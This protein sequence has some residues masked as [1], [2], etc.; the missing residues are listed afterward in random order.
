MAHFFLV[1]VHGLA[2]AA[3]PEGKEAPP[4]GRDEAAS[5]FLE[6]LGVLAA[7]GLL[8]AGALVL[9]AALR[10]APLGPP[11][12]EGI[13][14]TKPPWVFLPLYALENRLGVAS[15]FWVP[16]LLLAFLVIFPFL[17]RS[18]TD[19]PRRRWPVLVPLAV[20]TAGAVLLGVLAALVPG[21]AHIG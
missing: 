13:E 20:V 5:T 12:V 6:H 9:L 1:R 19:D 16:M 4:R 7:Y 14:V 18:P 3:G 10:P 8:L 15:L 11:G 17:D 21:V 2:V